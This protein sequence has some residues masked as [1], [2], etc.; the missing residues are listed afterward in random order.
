MIAKKRTRQRNNKEDTRRGKSRTLSR[1][2][3]TTGESRSLR[4]RSFANVVSMSPQAHPQAHP[5]APS[6]PPPHPNGS[7]LRNRLSAPAPPRTPSG[8]S[9]P[10]S[11]S[12]QAQPHAPSSPPPLS[13][14]S[15]PSPS[16]PFP[17]SPER[18]INPN[19][20][21]PLIGS[22]SGRRTHTPAPPRTPSRLSPPPSPPSLQQF[23]MKSVGLENSGVTCFL[24]SIM[25]IILHLPCLREYFADGANLKADLNKKNPDGF[26]GKAAVAVSQLFEKVS[27]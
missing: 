18:P 19:N 12:P 5:Q 27:E 22:P 11:P 23:D 8:P 6:P 14:S 1:Q 3:S 21:R 26:G 9:P 15:S 17:F 10:P 4:S 24:N 16:S 7:P 2:P 13:S 25:Q 20:K